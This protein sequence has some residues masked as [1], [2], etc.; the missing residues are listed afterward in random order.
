M[1]EQKGFPLERPRAGRAAS[2]PWPELERELQGYF[3][4]REISGDY[5]LIDQG[6]STWTQR[7]LQLTKSIPY[8][9][10]LTYK[11]LAEKAGVPGGARAVGQ[12]L[13]RNRTPLLIPCHRVIGQ[14]GKLIGFSSGLAWKE[15]LLKLE[16][17]VFS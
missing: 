7:V 10:T 17:V 4:G 12:A 16:G 9:Q 15:R 3:R 8:G 14:K 13:S 11:E 6:Y 2:L 1:L 5:P